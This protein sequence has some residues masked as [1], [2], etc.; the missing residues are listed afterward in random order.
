MCAEE[1]RFV[2]IGPLDG[3]MALPAFFTSFLGIQVHGFSSRRMTGACIGHSHILSTLARMSNRAAESSRPE[4]SLWGPRVSDFSDGRGAAIRKV[5]KK[6]EAS[7]IKKA[8]S[9]PV[10]GVDCF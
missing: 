2:E 7:G 6:I 5:L 9:E 3:G 8:P 1:I 10:D 4:V